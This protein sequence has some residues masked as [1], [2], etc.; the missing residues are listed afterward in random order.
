MMASYKTVK[1]M[2]T[3]EVLE[4]GEVSDEKF[5]LFLLVFLFEIFGTLDQ[6][7]LRQGE[8]SATN[9]AILELHRARS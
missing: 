9:K 5:K 4:S 2:F 6:I 3:K 7:A 1:E 8:I